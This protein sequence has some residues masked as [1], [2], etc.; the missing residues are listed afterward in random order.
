MLSPAYSLELL[1]FVDVDEAVLKAPASLREETRKIRQLK[2]KDRPAYDCAVVKL[3]QVHS[4]SEIGLTACKRIKTFMR[5]HVW[6]EDPTDAPL[7]DQAM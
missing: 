6:E 4:E 2:C 7:H 1:N 5:L 3:D